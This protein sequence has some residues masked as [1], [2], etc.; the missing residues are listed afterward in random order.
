MPKTKNGIWRFFASVKLALT[1]LIL[2]AAV[3]IIG[4][5]IKQGQE[6]SYY[7]QEYGTNLARF[8]QALDITNMYRSW[9]FSALLC[10]FAVN[11]IVC[12]IERF[13]PRRELGQG[14]ASTWSI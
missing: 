5:L 13:L 9:W 7:V 3:S 14:L 12:S 8:F 10:L 4:T 11:L 6:P 1:V 2:L